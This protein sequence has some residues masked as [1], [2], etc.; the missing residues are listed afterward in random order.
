[1]KKTT[2]LCC[3]LD[4]KI[5]RKCGG[6]ALAAKALGSSMHF[7]R[8]VR[9]WLFVRDSELWNLDECESG[10]FPALN[11]ELLSFAT[12]PQTLLCILC[13]IS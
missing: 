11:V 3:L 8:E 9:E 7:K 4:N 2:Q 1:M 13:N 10:I 12:M 6:L 5:V